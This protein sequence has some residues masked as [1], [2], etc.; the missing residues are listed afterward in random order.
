[1]RW[2]ETCA[3][4]QSAV[5]AS[6]RRGVRAKSFAATERRGYNDRVLKRAVQ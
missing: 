2:I 3:E 1:M 4:G 6:L 5:A